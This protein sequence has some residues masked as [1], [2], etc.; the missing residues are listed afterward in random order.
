MDP[1]NQTSR[2]VAFELKATGAA[3]TNSSLKAS[4][5]TALKDYFLRVPFNS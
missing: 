5:K 3:K 1:L 2:N 4:S